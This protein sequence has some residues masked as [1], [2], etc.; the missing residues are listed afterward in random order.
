[1]LRKYEKKGAPSWQRKL[2]LVLGSLFGATFLLFAVWAVTLYIDQARVDACLDKGGSYDFERN[3]CDFES[4]HAGP[5][6]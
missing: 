4:N 1:M 3:A 6:D 5:E 2:V